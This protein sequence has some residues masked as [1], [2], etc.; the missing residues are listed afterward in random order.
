[1]AL[2]YVAL[3]FA[4]TTR[5]ACVRELR[6]FDEEAVAD[7]STGS[8]IR[9]LDRL[10]VE[11]AGC[12]PPGAGDTLTGFDR[13]RVLL[14][15][16]RRA[17]G[18]RIESTIECLGCRSRFDLHFSLTDLHAAVDSQR[19]E[20]A[21][22]FTPDGFCHL[23]DGLVFRLPTGREECDAAALPS[24]EAH[25]ALIGKVVVSSSRPVT[26]PELDELLARAAPLLDLDLDATCP[27]CH[28]TQ[29]VHFSLQAYLLE[30]LL[31]E[32]RRLVSDLH[33]LAT[34]YGWSRRDILELPRGDRRVHVELIESERSPRRRPHL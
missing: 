13:D 33:R 5:R 4:G 23:P 1:M 27:E 14:A 11:A 18:N 9:M 7:T 30:S 34:V 22:D 32:R 26:A 25:A 24:G 19:V 15:I 8:A 29:K 16:Y 12:L 10:L 20:A 21:L 17:Y 28:R 2:D 31:K 3:Q 6:G